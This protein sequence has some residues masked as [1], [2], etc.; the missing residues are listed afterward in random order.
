MVE[1]S[2]ACSWN[3]LLWESSPVSKQPYSGG[4][5]CKCSFGELVEEEGM[6]RRTDATMRLRGN[7]ASLHISYSSSSRAH[8]WQLATQPGALAARQQQHA[9]FALCAAALCWGWLVVLVGWC[10]LVGGVG[11]WGWTEPA[12]ELG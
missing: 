6:P 7:S 8:L 12:E 1:G 9:D 11:W 3:R 10:W 4:T 5:T 2:P